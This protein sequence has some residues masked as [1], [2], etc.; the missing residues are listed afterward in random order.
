MPASP[1]PSRYNKPGSNSPIPRAH[2]DLRLGS[3]LSRYKPMSSAERPDVPFRVCIHRGRLKNGQTR[4]TQID[5]LHRSIAEFIEL[6]SQ[7]KTF[8]EVLSI[9]ALRSR[10]M[11]DRW[12]VLLCRFMR[13]QIS[14]RLSGASLSLRTSRTETALQT[15]QLIW[16]VGLGNSFGKRRCNGCVK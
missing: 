7:T 12:A 1:F 3:T 11:S 4:A 9:S 14:A 5:L 16:S 6:Q 15:M 8:S 2:A 13:W 10:T